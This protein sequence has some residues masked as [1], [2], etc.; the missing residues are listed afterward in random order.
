VHPRRQLIRALEKLTSQHAD[1][2][3]R[4]ITE[5]RA[6]GDIESAEAEVHAAARVL[7]SAWP[8]PRPGLPRKSSAA[9]TPRLNG[10]APAP[11]SSGLPG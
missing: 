3:T 8:R 5:L 2:L 9:G 10:T 6:A 4:A 1:T 7:T 11:T